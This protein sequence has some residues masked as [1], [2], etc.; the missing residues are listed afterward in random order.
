MKERDRK[1]EKYIYIIYIWRMYKDSKR[2]GVKPE[3]FIEI[4]FTFYFTF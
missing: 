2:G 3:H 1:R 4:Q